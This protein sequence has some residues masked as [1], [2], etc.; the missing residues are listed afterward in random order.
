MAPPVF[1]SLPG[2]TYP[3]PS[4]VEWPTVKQDALSGK[5]IRVPLVT[6]PIRHWDLPFSFLR[7]DAAF[8]EWQTFVG[9]IN[10]LNG[11]AQLFAYDDPNYDSVSAQSFGAGDGTTLS[12]QLVASLGGFAEP[13]FLVN[14]APQI[15]VNGVL[16]TVTTDYTISAYGVVTF[17]VAPAAAAPL[18]WTGNFYWPCRLDDEVTSLE[19]FMNKLFSCKSLK[20]SSEKLP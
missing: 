13:V 12:F 20:I 18:T 6:Y 9:F 11:P 10:S 15:F 16:K 5:R 2:I 14:G 1:P 17:T 3:I 8:T 7:T 19:L 4:S